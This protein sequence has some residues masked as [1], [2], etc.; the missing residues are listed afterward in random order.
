MTIPV[1]A[2]VIAILCIAAVGVSLRLHSHD[3]KT[4]GRRAAATSIIL[5]ER[6]E[7]EAS[8]EAVA[9]RLQTT[10]DSI[11]DAFYTVDRDWSVTYVNAAAERLLGLDR[12]DLLGRDIR[13]VFPERH[14]LAPSFELMARAMESMEPA[15]RDA[16]HSSGQWY[17]LRVYPSALGLAVYLR[18]VTDSYRAATA[19]RMFAQNIE[20]AQDAERTA[21]AR[22]LHDDIG[23]AL[24]AL[25]MDAARL[26]RMSAGDSAA[27][28]V[29][30]GMIALVDNTLEATR[31]LAMALHPVALDDIGLSAAIEIH[32]G[33]TA[34]RAD[35]AISCDLADV[36]PIEAARAKAV[37]RILQESVTNIVRHAEATRVRVRLAAADGEVVLEVTDD[38]VGIADEKR[39]R[40][41]FGIAGMRERAAALDGTLMIARVAPHGT[42]IR[43]RLPLV[44]AAAS[45]VPA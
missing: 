38:G 44:T 36:E 29:A 41:G 32:L 22:E 42:R 10:L 2:A 5:S 35:L 6:D 1:T 17:E 7:A 31:A 9:A 16:M 37:Y 33:H 34:R 30:A 43:L 20:A 3:R 25:R 14:R 39:D 12:T 15:H 28:G 19:L 4:E 8:L 45:R 13:R 23:Q 11:T 27:S 21:I 24:T 26:N 18:D 40:P